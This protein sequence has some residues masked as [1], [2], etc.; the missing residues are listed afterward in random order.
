MDFQT[1]QGMMGQT[2]PLGF[3][4]SFPCQQTSLDQVRGRGIRRCA[5]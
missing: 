3:T 2:L 5:G 4:F 1:K